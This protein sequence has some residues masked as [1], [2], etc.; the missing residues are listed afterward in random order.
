[1]SCIFVASASFS[2]LSR[3]IGFRWG[4]VSAACGVWASAGLGVTGSSGCIGVTVIPG[5][6]GCVGLAGGYCVDGGEA[7]LRAR[8]QAVK[9][10]EKESRALRNMGTPVAACCLFHNSLICSNFQ[11]NLAIFRSRWVRCQ[12]RA[13]RATCPAFRPKVVRC[14]KTPNLTTDD[15]DH[16]DLDGS[17][18]VNSGSS[19]KL[20]NPCH[21]CLFVSFHH[22][23]YF[24][25]GSRKR[26]VRLVAA[27]AA[28]APRWGWKSGA[29]APR[30]ERLQK[31][32]LAPQARAQRS[33]SAK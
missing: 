18:T 14:T 3:S 12:S 16:T 8:L 6:D 24:F 23:I 28:G 22:E 19:L 20:A 5:R 30:K 9:T 26:V 31:P 25:V 4:V 13:E 17:K 2:R 21:P 10:R 33:R 15:A 29:L 27:S 11:P 7:W 32:F 1:M